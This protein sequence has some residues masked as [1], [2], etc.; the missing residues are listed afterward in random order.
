MIAREMLTTYGFSAYNFD[1]RNMSGEACRLVDMEIDKLVDACYKEALAILTTNRR[2]LELLKE[3]L[4]EEEIV[5][6]QWVYDLVCGKCK[7]GRAA[8]LD[9]LDFD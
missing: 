3:K 8:D 4:I 1:Y 6:G 2:Q 7:V 9:S 5:D